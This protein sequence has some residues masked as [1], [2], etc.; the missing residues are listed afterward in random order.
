MFWK[1]Y[2][3]DTGKIVRAGFETEDEAKDWLEARSEDLDDIYEVEEMDQDEID[4]WQEDNES[5]DDFDEDD[6]IEVKDGVGFGDDYYDGA[7]LEE[8]EMDE[9]FDEEDD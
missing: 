5:E 4:Q 3:I 9:A 6:A 8:E 2:H 1:V 7:D